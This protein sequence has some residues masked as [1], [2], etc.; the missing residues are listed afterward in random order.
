MNH[1][2]PLCTLLL[3][4]AAT[5]SAVA[6]TNRTTRLGEMEADAPLLRL[7]ESPASVNADTFPYAAGIGTALPVAVLAGSRAEL[8]ALTPPVDD[9][10]LWLMLVVAGGLVAF[11]LRRKQKSLQHRPLSEAV[12]R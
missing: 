10:E 5:S 6:A 11:H 3:G 1:V 9:S 7:L 12:Y 2:K 8:P 4:L